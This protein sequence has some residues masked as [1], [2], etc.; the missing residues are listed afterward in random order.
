MIKG[1]IIDLPVNQN[2]TSPLATCGLVLG[3][4]VRLLG[5]IARWLDGV[6]PSLPDTPESKTFVR[7]E[8]LDTSYIFL[9]NTGKRLPRKL[10]YDIPSS[11][12]RQCTRAWLLIARTLRGILTVT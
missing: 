9:N 1:D 12:A 5:F 4:P 10:C 2:R 8:R 11:V 7:L 6:N 3:S